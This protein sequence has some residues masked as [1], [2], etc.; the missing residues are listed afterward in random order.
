MMDG[1]RISDKFSDSPD[2][3]MPTE[4]KNLVRQWLINETVIKNNM[5]F[6]LQENW[7]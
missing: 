6:S 3:K 7:S 2:L 5:S 1:S 4:D